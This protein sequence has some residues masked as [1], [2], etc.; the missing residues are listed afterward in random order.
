MALSRDQVQEKLNAEI[1]AGNLIVGERADR[2]FVGKTSED[3]IFIITEE[4]EAMLAALETGKK[5]KVAE[6]VAEVEAKEAAPKKG[7]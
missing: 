7:K 2:V 5:A 6:V 4:G 1:V 3:G